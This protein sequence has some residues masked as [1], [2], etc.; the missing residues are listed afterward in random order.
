[1]YIM[2]ILSSCKSPFRQRSNAPTAGNTRNLKIERM[3]RR[4]STHN[5]GLHDGH[6]FILQI[7]VQTIL[8]CSNGRKYA[9]S[10]D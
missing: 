6:P 1:V 4:K 10:E 5:M 2:A 3:R 8:Q 7:T 9:Q